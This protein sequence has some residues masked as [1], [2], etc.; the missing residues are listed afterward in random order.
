MLQACVRLH[1][2]GEPKETY[3][4]TEI[5]ALERSDGENASNARSM[6]VDRE[7][8]HLGLG[9]I[10]SPPPGRGGGR[11]GRAESLIRKYIGN[12]MHSR[13]KNLHR[14]RLEKEKI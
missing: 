10:R 5:G 6:A 2:K 4:G 1:R 3:G 12:K 13:D 14:G 7:F 9:V 11:A 8:G